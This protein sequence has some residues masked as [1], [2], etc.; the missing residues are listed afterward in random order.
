MYIVVGRDGSP[1]V[2]QNRDVLVLPTTDYLSAPT[3]PMQAEAPQFLSLREAH[4]FRVDAEC[5]TL[6][7]QDN[8]RDMTRDIR[9]VLRRDTRAGPF[10]L[11]RG[12]AETMLV[13]LMHGG[14]TMAEYL[15][16]RMEGS[17]F[18]R[19]GRSVMA[20]QH[21]GHSLARTAREQLD[22]REF[23]TLG[24]NRMQTVVVGT[25]PV[26]EEAPAFSFTGDADA[27]ADWEA[28]RQTFIDS[29]TRA[30]AR[31][32]PAPVGSAAPVVVNPAVPPGQ[33]M[34][35]PHDYR[36]RIVRRKR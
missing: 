20:A 23:S 5:L 17:A 28:G 26:P 3:I 27:W 18:L 25:R 21:L 29:L 30:A 8:H 15:S 11:T 1:L 34:A 31:M 36:L 7:V 4:P 33:M 13:T 16:R 14:R 19:Q 9:V 35:V 12:E 6:E 22:I 2:N 10:F 24:S 32:D